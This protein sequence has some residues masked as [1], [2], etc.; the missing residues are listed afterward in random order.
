MENHSLKICWTWTIWQKWQIVI[1][2]D[3]RNSLD[4]HPWDGLTIFIKNNKVIA[5]I[6]NDN[7]SELINY[8]KSEWIDFKN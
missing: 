2:K 6:K 3:V 1:P 4:L 7:I 8:A 5:M